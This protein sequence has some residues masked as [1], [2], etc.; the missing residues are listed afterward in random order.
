LDRVPTG[1]I[2]RL[3]GRDIGADRC[4]AGGLHRHRRAHAEV[5]RSARSVDKRDL[6]PDDM[7]P[8]GER[9]EHRD[10]VSGIHGLADALTVELDHRVR[11]E[12]H[13]AG[14]SDRDGFRQCRLRR[15]SLVDISG[16]DVERDAQQREQLTPARGSRRQPYHLPRYAGTKT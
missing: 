13:V 1:S 15:G 3:A 2:E 14:A 4:V 5:Q 7:R 11:R 10:R 12:R 9:L 16:Y 8:A 6:A